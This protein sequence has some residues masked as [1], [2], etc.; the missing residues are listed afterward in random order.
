VLSSHEISINKIIVLQNKVVKSYIELLQQA[1]AKLVVYINNDELDCAITDFP[2]HTLVIKQTL[3]N[4]FKDS[5][6]NLH[7]IL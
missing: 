1:K 3:S 5:V 2:V 7:L 6:N 4:F